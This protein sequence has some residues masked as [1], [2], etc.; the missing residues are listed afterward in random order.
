MAY[1]AKV[2]SDGT[3]LDVIVADQDFID[4]NTESSDD[5]SYIETFMDADGS[6]ERYN[7]ASKGHLYNSDAGA[8]HK[9][10]PYASWVLNETTCLWEPP[11][12]HPTDDNIYNWNE[13]AYQADNTTGW[14]II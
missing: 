2:S 6:S 9:L 4:N 11:I 13:D 10:Q 3:V 14:E 8:F 12:V 7:Y 5:H 1:F